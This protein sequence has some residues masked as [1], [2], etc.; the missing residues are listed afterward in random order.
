MKS[1]I[2]Y[3][4]CFNIYF[5]IPKSIKGDDCG[6]KEIKIYRNRLYSPKSDKITLSDMNKLNTF[7]KQKSLI[8]SKSNS[9]IDNAD[10]INTH[11]L[12]SFNTY[13]YTIFT[14]PDSL[15]KFPNT[16]EYHTN[17][18]DLKQLIDLMNEPTTKEYGYSN[19]VDDKTCKVFKRMVEGY[20]VILIKC[21]ANIPYN[22]DIVYEAIANL[23]IRKQWDTVFSELRVVNYEGENGAEILYMIVKSPVIIVDDREFVQQKKTW[24]NFPTEKSHILHFI[25]L[26]NPAC[27]YNKKCVRAET[28]ISGYYMQ[29]D[30]EVPG[31]SILGVL[32]QTDLKGN[33]PH[34]LVNKLAPKSSKGWIKSLFKGCKIVIDNYVQ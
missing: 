24:K 16:N 28:I 21:I 11:R 18:K 20:P 22:K 13:K 19:V 3:S 15:I 33:I 8:G 5:S 26:E 9:N 7:K 4:D 25:S 14:K 30:P 31:H 2:N 12:A 10:E 34:F 17:D 27:P 29:D 32:S 23:D 6:M 1:K